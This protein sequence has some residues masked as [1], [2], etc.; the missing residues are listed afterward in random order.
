MDTDVIEPSYV[1]VVNRTQQRREFMGFG[2]MHV[3]QP[4]EERSISRP[5]AEWVFTRT[6]GPML[7]H[8]EE[9]GYA[10][11]LGIKSGPDELVGLLPEGVFETALLT[12]VESVEGWNTAVLDR[13]PTKTQIKAVPVL[14]AD[15]ANQGGALGRGAM[16][17][18][19]RVMKE[20]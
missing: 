11:W 2:R 16:G 18:P 20:N 8:T 15:F 1:V 5:F 10:H 9:Q 12:P 19:S 17:A 14:R 13:D 6:D 4:G 7:T 3:F